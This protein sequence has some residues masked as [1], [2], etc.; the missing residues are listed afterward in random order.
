MNKKETTCLKAVSLFCL[1]GFTS[2]CSCVFKP[3]APP[4]FQSDYFYYTE[5]S[6]C[7]RIPIQKTRL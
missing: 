2:F 1:T 3:E 5:N 7:L 6:Q 4:L